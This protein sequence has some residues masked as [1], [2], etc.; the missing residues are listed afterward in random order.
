[1]FLFTNLYCDANKLKDAVYFL[2]ILT[3]YFK[4]F[5]GNSYLYLKVDST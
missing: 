4:G 3:C 5:C 1:M 2:R